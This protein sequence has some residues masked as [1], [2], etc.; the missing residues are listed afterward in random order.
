VD[1]EA[2]QAQGDDGRSY[3]QVGLDV[4]LGEGAFFEAEAKVKGTDVDPEDDEG[5]GQQGKQDGQA[6]DQV[7]GARLTYRELL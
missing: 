7:A 1:V 5:V 2:K 4:D 6:A 3:V